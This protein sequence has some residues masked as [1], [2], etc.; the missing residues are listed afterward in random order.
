M[1]LEDYI[2]NIPNFPIE[3]IQFKDITPLLNNKDSFHEAIKQL[4]DFGREVNATI[5]MG[6]DA[7]GFIF[8]C[9]VAYELNVGFV[10]VRKPGKLPRETIKESYSL[11]YGENVLEIHKDSFKKGDRV[12]IIDDLMATGGTIEASIKLAKQLGAEVVGVAVLIELLELNGKKNLNGIP[13]KSL[14]KY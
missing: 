8:G 14:I 3:G 11:E 7:R 10:P 6:P 13:F 12:L 9:P 2:A 1:K 4:A 5:V